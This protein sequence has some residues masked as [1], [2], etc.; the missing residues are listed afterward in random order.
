MYTENVHCKQSMHRMEEC[1]VYTTGVYFRLTTHDVYTLNTSS[2]RIVLFTKH[3]HIFFVCSNG[4]Q[5]FG[6]YSKE[7]HSFLIFFVLHSGVF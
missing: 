3:Y 5:A 4:L 2:F 7:A 6:F 1:L